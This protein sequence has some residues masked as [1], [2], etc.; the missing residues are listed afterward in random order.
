[1]FVFRRFEFGW[2]GAM[3]TCFLVTPDPLLAALI[4]LSEITADAGLRVEMHTCLSCDRAGADDILVVDARGEARRLLRQIVGRPRITRRVRIV[5]IMDE[6]ASSEQRAEF[7]D[8]GV[9]SAVPANPKR[10]A[11]LLAQAIRDALEESWP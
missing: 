2:P 8:A 7:I 9:T 5:A 6:T 11:E 1:M 4:R 3:K 10:L